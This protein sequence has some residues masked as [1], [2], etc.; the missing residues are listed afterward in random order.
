MDSLWNG[1][2]VKIYKALGGQV[3]LVGGCVRDYLLRHPMHDRDMTTPLTPDEVEA[4]LEKA[5]IH[6]TSVGKHYGTITAIIGNDPY[7]ITTL[8][9]EEKHDGRH[10]E[11]T[12]TTS[13]KA[14][15]ARRDFTVNALSADIKNKIFDYT[16]GRSDLAQG[17][18]RFIGD[19]EQR[20]QE[21]YLRILRYFRFWSAISTLDLDPVILKICKK[22]KEGLNMLSK[23][24]VRDE[25]FRL[26]CTPRAEEALKAMKKEG[27]LTQEMLAIDFSKKQVQKLK[28]LNLNSLLTKTGFKTAGGK[29]E[30]KS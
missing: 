15:A 20:I 27:I 23:D 6:Y 11:M 25:L 10:A 13:Y 7:E 14:D 24:R 3:R 5:K 18:I 9:K 17:L 22:H 19:P 21:D 8:R 1:A 30:P 16:T 12:W 2:A 29:N 26:I 28:E 4:A